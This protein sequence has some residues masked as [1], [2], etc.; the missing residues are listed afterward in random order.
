MRRTIL[1]STTLAMFVLTAAFAV[2]GP[3]DS[4]HSIT[5]PETRVELPAGDGKMKVETYCNICHTLDYITMQPRFSRA[6]WTGTV[7]K[8]IKVMGA[9][10]SE[11]DAK[12]IID[13]LVAHYGSGA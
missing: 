8:M 1:F 3:Q 2:A 4:L 12:T 13:Y 7:N 5:L 10:I 9:Q 11:Q 6:Q